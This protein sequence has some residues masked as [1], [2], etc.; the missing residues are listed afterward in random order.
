M[1]KVSVIV[2]SF[3]HAVYITQAVESVL[4][5]TF[6]DWELLIS[7][8]ASTDDTLERLKPY[9]T[10]TK[11]RIFP[12]RVRLGAVQQIHFLVEQVQGEYIALL[13]SD[14]YWFPTKLEEQVAFLT[15]N[16]QVEACFTQAIMVNEAGQELSEQDFPLAKLFFQPNRTRAEWLRNI[17]H[18]GNSLCHPSVLVRRSYDQKWKLNAAL[19][20]LPD[21]DIWVRMLLQVDI[22]VLQKPLTAHRRISGDNVSTDSSENYRRLMLEQ[23]WIFEQM[24]DAI[25][26]DLFRQAFS[27]E[28]VNAG[29]SLPQELQCEKF[30]LLLNGTERN[31]FMRDRA[32]DYFIEHGRDQNFMRYM[33]EKYKFGEAAFY[34]LSCMRPI[35]QPKPP[36]LVKRV[37]RKIYKIV[38]VWRKNQ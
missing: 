35:V 15:A 17:W 13:N 9:Q 10:H 37:C 21:M 25:D 16:P 14:D 34:D 28:F 32:I 3:N 22:H 5:Q 30:F 20:Q 2:P 24:M 7:D 36:N 4:A 33:K 26:D 19:R 1:P 23:S 27:G 29:A 18:C 31:E 11:I 38:N 12:Q 6:Q 8:D